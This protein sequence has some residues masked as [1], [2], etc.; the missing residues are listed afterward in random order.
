MGNKQQID[1]V[2]TEEALSGNVQ[3]PREGQDPKTHKNLIYILI[4]FEG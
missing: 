4:Q 1:V 3:S 2:N